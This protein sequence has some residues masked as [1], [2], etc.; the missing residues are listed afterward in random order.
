METIE[1]FVNFVN[2]VNFWTREQAQLQMCKHAER[3]TKA[4]NRHYRLASAFT[5]QMVSSECHKR[6]RHVN[7]SHAL[8]NDNFS[9]EE[10][11]VGIIRKAEG[12]K[13]AI[14]GISYFLGRRNH[15]ISALAIVTG[16]AGDEARH[17][18]RMNW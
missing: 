4:L 8:G 14:K 15:H 10:E 11:A 5:K 7:Q 12:C 17:C 16:A 6:E 18:C 1:G 3:T 13:L 2:F 9:G